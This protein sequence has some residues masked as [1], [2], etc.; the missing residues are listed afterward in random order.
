[1]LPASIGQHPYLIVIMMKSPLLIFFVITINS[2]IFSQERFQ[3]IDEN[4]ECV[5]FVSVTFFYQSD[6]VKT[7]STISGIVTIENSMNLDSIRLNHV[8]HLSKV[9]SRNELTDTVI[10]ES[11]VLELLEVNVSS[12]HVKE[13]RKLGVRQRLRNMRIVNNVGYEIVTL[14]EDSNLVGW[15]VDEFVFHSVKMEGDFRA[16]YRIV[17]YEN[18]N[19]FPSSR[20]PIDEMHFLDAD[21]KNKSSIDLS[22]RNIE[23]PSSGFFVGI[24]WLGNDSIQRVDPFDVQYSRVFKSN[25]Y[26]NPQNHPSFSRIKLL[27]NN[28]NRIDNSNS[29]YLEYCIPTFQLILSRKRNN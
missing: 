27:D 9:I 10:L 16:Y 17:F 29:M 12:S 6:S 26:D 14:F 3:I 18:D 25:F 2:A 5:P 1:M 23:F 28:W 7:Y 11:K 13:L 8:S 19:G 15:N 21:M 4:F 20:I 22:K 24:E